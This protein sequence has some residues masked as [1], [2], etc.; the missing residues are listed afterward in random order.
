MP[1]PTRPLVA[2]LVDRF[3]AYA[4][5]PE[6]RAPHL[7]M[8]SAN[9]VVGQ[10]IDLPIAR[11]CAP[12]AVCVNTCYFARDTTAAPSNLAKQNAVMET[13]I[14]DPEAAAHRI[15]RELLRS[16]AS[17]LRWNGGGDLFP[18]AVACVN[19][20]GR[21]YPEIAIWVVTRRPRLAAQIED[22]E[23]VFVHLSL[24][25]SSRSRLR[26]WLALPR[27]PERWFASYQCARDEEPDLDLLARAGF[28]VVFRDAY[29]ALPAGVGPEGLRVS[30]P[31]N[32]ADTVEDG[33]RRCG[34]CWTP[35]GVAMRDES[36]LR[37][38]SLEGGPSS[39]GA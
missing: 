33:C 13:I 38:W 10:S 15:A 37:L 29:R 23:R 19:A 35:A 16:G 30:C 14:A 24:D 17:F 36:R 2:R 11:T 8:L 9:R 32:G 5:P 26:E 12:T 18:E 39:P 4:Y 25:R 28:S 1:T 31:L 34:R 22:A 20:I 6:P 21:L 3:R 7:A 27:R